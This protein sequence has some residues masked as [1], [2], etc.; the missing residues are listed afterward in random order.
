M[1]LKKSVL[2]TKFTEE[3]LKWS[4]ILDKVTCENGS[5]TVVSLHFVKFFRTALLSNICER[6]EAVVQKCSVKKVFLEIPQNSQENTCATVSFIKFYEIFK[7]TFFYRTLAIAIL[8]TASNNNLFT[9]SR[10]KQYHI[11]FKAP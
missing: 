1:F 6:P 4:K 3:H 5:I 9:T 11:F 7:N 8:T 2:S 10:R